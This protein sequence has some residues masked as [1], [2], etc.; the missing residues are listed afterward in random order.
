MLKN[1]MQFIVCRC[2]DESS[3]S[4]ALNEAPFHTKNDGNLP[5]LRNEA[6][7]D[8]EIRIGDPSGNGRFKSERQA[9]V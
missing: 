9:G 3:R 8:S 4:R 1:F 7:F 5:D 2:A 6:R